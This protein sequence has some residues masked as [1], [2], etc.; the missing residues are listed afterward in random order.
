MKVC[1]LS[2][3][4]HFP[5]VLCSRVSFRLLLPVSSSVHSVIQIA[6][7]SRHKVVLDD[8]SHFYNRDILT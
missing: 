4:Y 8:I 2:Q 6:S 5:A 3:G 1:S 7:S